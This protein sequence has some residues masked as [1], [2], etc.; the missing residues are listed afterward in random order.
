MQAPCRLSTAGWCGSGSAAGAR[1]EP[2]T[3]VVRLPCCGGR[4]GGITESASR[5]HPTLGWTLAQVQPAVGA[6]WSAATDGWWRRQ[7]RFARSWPALGRV[8]REASL[9]RELGK[10]HGFRRWCEASL[11]EVRAARPRQDEGAPSA[12]APGG[13]GLSAEQ[14]V[15]L[16]PARLHLACRLG[17][18]W[19]C[20]NSFCMESGGVEA[21]RRAR[22]DGAAQIAEAPKAVLTAAVRYGPGAGL[23]GAAC[24]GQVG[25]PLGGGRGAGRG[26]HQDR[27][28]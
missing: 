17:R 28:A 21:F 3:P 4:A 13:G 1:L 16:R 9:A 2:R 5:K 24:P 11:V 8:R 10:L 20:L 22:C 12:P 25:R 26:A 6:T 18:R 27:A 15:L 7:G 19:L 14:G 23:A